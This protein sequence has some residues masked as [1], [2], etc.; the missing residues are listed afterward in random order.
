MSCRRRS[1]N[2]WNVWFARPATSSGPDFWVVVWHDAHPDGDEQVRAAHHGGIVDIAGDRHG[3]GAVVED[4]IGEIGVA[5]VG[6]LSATG[7]T[8]AEPWLWHVV[9]TSEVV[10]PMSSCSAPTLC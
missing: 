1:V 2:G 8:H 4:L 6:H 3:D 9:G 7:S 10:M 5:H